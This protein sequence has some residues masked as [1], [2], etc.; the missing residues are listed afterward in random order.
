M[1]EGT[2]LKHLLVPF[3]LKLDR[4]LQFLTAH[5]DGTVGSKVDRIELVQKWTSIFNQKDFLQRAK[6][7]QRNVTAQSLR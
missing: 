7:S 3:L 6:I 1:R 5:L 4:S 2:N